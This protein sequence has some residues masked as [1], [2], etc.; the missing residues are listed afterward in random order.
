[1]SYPKSVTELDQWLPR[2]SNEEIYDR[3]THLLNEAQSGDFVDGRGFSN[4]VEVVSK[5]GTTLM[6][7]SGQGYGITPWDILSIGF[8]L[9]I[10]TTKGNRND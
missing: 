6:T 7:T 1:M 2:A 9:S 10:T 3:G 8:N 4:P 5:T